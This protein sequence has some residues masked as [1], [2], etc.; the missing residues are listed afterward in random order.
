MAI[1]RQIQIDFWQDELIAEFT[2]EDKLFYLYLM[3]NSKT[4]QCGIYRINKRIMAF[5]IGWN[6]ETVD[7]MLARFVS[8]NRIKYNDSENEVFILNWLKHNSARSP[9]VAARVD[10]EL[11][12]VKTEDFH[13]DAVHLCIEYGYPIHTVSIQVRNKNKNKNK[14]N[15]QEETENTTNPPTDLKETENTPIPYAEIIDYLNE[16]TGRSFR[17][18]DSNK[19]YIKARWNEGYKV[20]DFKQV[21][22]NKCDEWLLDEKMSQFLQPS[23]VFGPKF[24]QYLNQRVHKPNKKIT[25]AEWEGN[26]G[27]KRYL[28]RTG[29]ATADN[30]QPTA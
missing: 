20:D 21:V 15:N 12:E 29:L 26:D 28:E 6:V 25:D 5:D 27:F 2:P 4:N 11:K 24:D 19:K 14:N 23:T 13:D 7:K 16:K 9:K 30:Q 10:M 8:Y 22:D 1:F 3:T 18:V 17:N